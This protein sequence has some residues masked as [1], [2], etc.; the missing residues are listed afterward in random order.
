MKSPIFIDAPSLGRRSA[1]EELSA[2][3]L[4]ERA[5]IAP[6]FLYDALGSRL[7]EA[8]T[9]LDEYYPTRTEARILA[10]HGAAIFGGLASGIPLIEPGAGSC[11]KA[12]VALRHVRPSCFVALEIDPG[13][14]H[15]GLQRLQER[16][17][18]LDL[19]AVGT[20][21]AEGIVLP[22]PLADGPCNLF[23]PGSSIGNFAP[24]HTL[25]MLR[26]LHA[27]CAGGQLVI[28]ADTV[29]ET[30]VLE[31][32]Y[33]DA[34]GVTA[35]FNLN[36]LRHANR[37]LGADFALA[38]WRHRAHFDV[39][40]RRIEMHLETRRPVTVR[41]APQQQ[42]QFAEGARIHTEYSCKWAPTEFK[43]LLRQAGFRD[44]EC[45]IDERGWFAVYRAC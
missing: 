15:Q 26:S 9:E 10:E 35:A 12:E 29:K 18:E 7:F 2:G 11:R 6:K 8:I 42:R 28:G 1:R 3:L 27:A 5:T 22:A 25:R 24:P 14:A 34:L 37:V 41:W 16:H 20:D 36:L 44:I 19:M 4:A 21:F 32:A 45:W 33:D 17:P 40:A 13:F 39:D 38:D 43:Q 30:A 23:Y 31:A